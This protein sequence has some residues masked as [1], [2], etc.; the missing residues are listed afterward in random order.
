MGTKDKR[1]D[2]YIA[3][4]ADFARPVLQ[5]LR[6]VVHEGCPEVEE[7]LKWSVPFFLHK[8][9]L[10]CMAA[11]KQHCTFGFWKA[12]LFLDK[13][14]NNSVD[15]MGQFGR[16][17]SKKDL[18]PRRLLLQWVRK[19]KQLN[20]D[21]VAKRRKPRNVKRELTVPT[22]FTSALRKDKKALATFKG[23]PYSKKKDYVEWITE[24]KTDA[25]RNRRLN[26]AIAWLAEGKARNWKYERC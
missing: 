3:K 15:A 18:P 23:F 26:T 8:G 13:K 24:A 17:T 12:S 11:F 4:S 21:G 5:E 7:T 20:D 19:A 22:Y 2:A 16:L 14:E 9:I 1:V 25:T 10:C 6:A